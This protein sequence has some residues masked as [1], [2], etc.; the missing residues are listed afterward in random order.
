MQANKWIKNMEKSNNLKVI[1]QSDANYMQVLEV[2]ISFGLPVLIENVGEFEFQIRNLFPA[3]PNHYLGAGEK[4]D[5]NLTPILEKNVIKHKG[6]LFI[7]SGDQMIEYNPDFRL[8]I[9]T[10]LRNP[11]Y[12]PEVM[13][14][15]SGGV[16]DNGA[17]VGEPVCGNDDVSCVI[18][19]PT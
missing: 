17:P 1:K 2:A 6:G 8:Y 16:R 3:S 9:T 4:L 11:R 19:R 13:V 18:K 10:C 14:M 15:V 12:P 7:K 5:S